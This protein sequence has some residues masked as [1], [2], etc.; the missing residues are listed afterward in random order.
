MFVV[1]QISFRPAKSVC[2][3]ISDSDVCWGRSQE[4]FEK[5]TDAAASLESKRGDLLGLGKVL[6][7][8]QAQMLTPIDCYKV[9]L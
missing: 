1:P 2:R 6:T 4:T 3:V 5:I 8:L 7:P 9:W